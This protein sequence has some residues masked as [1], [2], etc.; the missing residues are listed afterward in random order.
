MI[1]NSI[2]YFRVKHIDVIYYYVKNKIADELMKL[3]YI[4]ITDMMINELIKSL[5]AVKF[6]SF[7][8]IM[9]MSSELEKA[10]WIASYLSI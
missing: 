10:V 5:K 8:F 1:K 3:R 2:N 9:K 7:R 6:K 4:S